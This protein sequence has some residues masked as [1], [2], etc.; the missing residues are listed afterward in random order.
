MDTATHRSR[1]SARRRTLLVLVLLL[2]PMLSPAIQAQ[3]LYGSIVGNVKDSTGAMLPGAAVTITHNE[4]K[5]KRETVTD[6]AGAYRF[7][8]VQ[9]GTYTV[10]VTMT[11]LQ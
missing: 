2:S 11:G 9:P 3:V 10:T 6:V 1:M 7:P 4:T 8:N 5:S